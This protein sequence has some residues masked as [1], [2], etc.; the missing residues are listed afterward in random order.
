MTDLTMTWL[1]LSLK[2][3]LVVAASP[4]SDDADAIAFAVQAGAGAVVMRSLF[5]EQITA[6]QM[7][8]HH[9]VDAHTDAHAE[10]QGFLPET[11]AFSLDARPY[12][13]QLARLRQRVDVPL[14][15][16]LNGA[17]P[18]GWM[19]YAKKLQ[20]GGADAIELNLYD[21]ATSAAESSSAVEA[22]QLDVVRGVVGAVT[23]PVSVKLSPFYASVP[24]FAKRLEEVGARG[25]VVFNRFYQPDVDL[26]TLHV[27]RKIVLSSSAELPLRL[28]A[29]AVLA[30]TSKLSLA[31]TGGVHSGLDAAKAI[32]SGA[33]A[34]EL[35]SVLLRN[36]PGY[37]GVIR[38]EL[39]A[40]LTEKGYSSAAQARGVLRIGSAPAAHAWQRLNYARLLDS[41]QSR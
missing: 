25:V 32:L 40:W 14:I 7:A 23:I 18:G 19:D 11:D 37:L 33:H 13:D 38:A 36:G 8:A 22:R 29:L 17:T 34:V 6:E 35:A 20:A 9:F 12:L 2:T 28:Q 3:P 31:C 10:A 21:L 16:S 1:G 27:D 41:W 15:A 26:E 30:S 39:A 5:E 4:L 24:A